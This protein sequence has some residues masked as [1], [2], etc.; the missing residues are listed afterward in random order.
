MNDS[1]KDEADEAR[2]DLLEQYISLSEDQREQ[3]F[4]TTERA[5]KLTGMSRRTIQFWVECDYIE[6]IFVGKK[7]RIK[8][9]SLMTFLKNRVNGRKY[10]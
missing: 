9:D 7:Y 2:E 4:P 10:P 1:S 6:A 5:A 3:E 8:L